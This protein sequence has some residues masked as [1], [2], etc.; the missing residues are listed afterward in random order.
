MT[1][2]VTTSPQQTRALGEAFAALLEAGDVVLLVGS[3]GA[4]KTELTKGIAVG[5]GI[6]GPVVSP[7]FTL[8]RVYDG[9]LALV[10]ADL[11]RL[12]DGDDIADLGLDDLDGRVAV[13]E[14]GERA[15]ALA[16]DAVEIH[17]EMTDDPDERRISF[18]A[19]GPTWSTRL[20]ALC[21]LSC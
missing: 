20:P 6:E 7:T 3:L 8:A 11:Y 18:R 4:G 16:E 2:T 19:T 17:L 5:L 14:W 12:D 15:P 21:G 9:R 10:H 13:V 1:E